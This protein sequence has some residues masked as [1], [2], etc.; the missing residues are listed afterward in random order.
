MFRAI[1]AIVGAAFTLAGGWSV[2]TSL[3][4]LVAM[5]NALDRSIYGWREV[6]F[7]TVWL[8]F[9]F[10][11]VI[12]ALSLLRSAWRGRRRNIV[13]GPTLYVVGACLVIIALFMLEA[14]AL[15]PSAL[16]AGFG[17]ILMIVE[18]R[19]DLV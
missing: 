9:A 3:E 8:I 15:V 19:M 14:G 7:L 6:L 10:S 12:A 2:G 5:V 16:T 18:Y 13:P 11:L 1:V 17:L 4:A